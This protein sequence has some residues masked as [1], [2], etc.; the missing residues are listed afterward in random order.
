[1]KKRKKAIWPGV[2]LV[3]LLIV[4]IGLLVIRM[5]PPK[6]SSSAE[7]EKSGSLEAMQTSE[8]VQIPTP[9]IAEAATVPTAQD[10][11]SV[12]ARPAISD[13]D[14]QV[15]I[16]AGEGNPYELPAAG[17]VTAPGMPSGHNTEKV[18]FE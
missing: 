14:E 1:M 9:A 11:A 16:T 3:L 13:A 15:E 2:F 10:E 18:P 6:D 7:P 4:L 17:A 8:N 12:F 5:Q